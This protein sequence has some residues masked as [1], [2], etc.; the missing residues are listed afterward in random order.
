M[1]KEELL[2]KETFI[3][4][5][6]ISSEIERVEKEIELLEIAK[7]LQCQ[8]EF[9]TLLKVWKKEIKNSMSFD[10]EIY[11]KDIPLEGLTCDNFTCNQHGILK[12]GEIV[13]Y[14]PIIPIEIY[15]NK[16]T[17]NEK[18][19]LAFFKRNKWHTC[20]ADKDIIASAHKIV[21][22]SKKGIEITSENARGIIKYLNEVINKNID[23]IPVGTS[24]SSLGWD[25]IEFAPYNNSSILDETDEFSNIFN[26]FKEKGTYEDWYNLIKV[27]RKNTI[28]K[29]IMA[30]SFAS[31]LLEK[32]NITPYIVNVWSSASGTGKTV[33]CMVAISS[34]G[35]PSNKGLQFSS[36]STLN[37]YIKVASY[38]KN[39]TMFCDEFQKVK[40]N[41]NFDEVV[42]VLANGREKGRLTKDRKTEEN[43]YWN[44]NFLFTNNDK[45][46]RENFG[47]QVFN[48]IIDIECNDKIIDN[49][50]EVVRIIKNNY[51]FAGKKYIEYISKLDFVKINDRVKKY[52]YEI[53][54]KYNSTEKQATCIATLIVANELSQEC[55]FPEEEILTID[56][57]KDYINN[58][59][60][61]VTW[62]KAYS[63]IIN[64]FVAN[65]NKFDSTFTECWGR[66]TDYYYMVNKGILV[67]E[68]QKMGFEFDSIK[69]DWDKYGILEKNSQGRYAIYTK[70][71]QL[72][73]ASYIK[74]NKKEIFI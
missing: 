54:E 47:E 12:K 50:N 28:I 29:I 53:C 17:G 62:K 45:L 59:E 13:C 56:D 6:S 18:V 44:N 7:S 68:L 71:G 65:D 41:E 51:G 69:K 52:I 26:S 5:F 1:T 61:I 23:I 55:L 48:R 72:P 58:K 63:Y 36:D 34:W 19:K 35:D 42:M 38:L 2:K 31:P 8:K 3:K 33:A 25:E 16:T 20:V 9:K 22:L 14:H 37:Y 39:I 11:L 4:L 24:I 40:Y 70:V 74:I 10:N 32:L 66:S 30:C 60:E 49:G 21:K 67:R 64:H 27:L 73:K 15:T 43:G 46:T 57:F